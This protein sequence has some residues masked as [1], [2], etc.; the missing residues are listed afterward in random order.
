MKLLLLA[1]LS[2]I[3]VCAVAQGL[4]IVPGAGA[5]SNPARQG[6][7]A[8]IE[9]QGEIVVIAFFTHRANGDSTFYVASGPMYSVPNNEAMQPN[10]YP[11]TRMEGDLFVTNDGPVLN[12]PAHSGVMSRKVGIVRAEFG[13]L[14]VVWVYVDYAESESESLSRVFTLSKVTYGFGG[15][16][17]SF[18]SGKPCW[19]DL[20]GEW[21]F[22]D[23]SDDQAVPRRYNFTEMSSPMPLSEIRCGAG[24]SSVLTFRDITRSQVLRCVASSPDFDGVNRYACELREGEFGET[25]YWFNPSDITAARMVGSVGPYVSGY[26]R[27]PSKVTAFRVPP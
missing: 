23:Q 18:T 1:F 3:H 14:D 13:Y 15:I 11:A 5:Y 17:T 6:E 27:M 21:I 4:Q 9:V 2:L 24:A 16:G 22:V 19:P 25:L 12:Q 8:F 10:Y 7:G 20:R 26:A